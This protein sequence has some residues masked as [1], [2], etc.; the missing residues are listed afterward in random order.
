MKITVIIAA[1]NEEKTIAEIIK[2]VLAVKFQNSFAIGQIIVVD[3]GSTDRTQTA[4]KN[5]SKNPKIQI[6]TNPKNLGKGASIIKALK[7]A[8]GNII[9]T[10]DADLEYDPN[11]IPC[12][13]EPFKSPDVRVVYGSRMLA[14]N[15]PVSHWT[16]NLGGQLVT[17]ITNLLFRTNITDEP[18]GY[19]VFKREVISK[20]DLKSKGFEFCPEVTAKVAKLGLTIYEVPISYNPRP[21]NEKKIK[22]HDGV[23]AIYY[24]FKYRFFN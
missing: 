14:K 18:S 19:K 11:D 2:K 15:H 9:L 6:I 24:L 13:I 23:L 21:M 16:F 7:I 10:Q 4:L 8:K 12:L 5:F 22:W 3:D 17:Q 20:M 1:Y